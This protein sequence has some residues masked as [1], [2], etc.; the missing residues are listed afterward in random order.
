MGHRI[1]AFAVL[2]T[3][4]LLPSPMFLAK[5]CLCPAQHILT[6]AVAMAYGQDG[7]WSKHKILHCQQSKIT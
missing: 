3:S 1:N 4:V 2:N 5:L 7:Q 6:N